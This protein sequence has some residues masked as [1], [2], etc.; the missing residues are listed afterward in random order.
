MVTGGQGGPLGGEGGGQPPCPP[1]LCYTYGVVTSENERYGEHEKH[2]Y[3]KRTREQQ[4]SKRQEKS[5]TLA[6]CLNMN[7]QHKSTLAL[8]TNL[9]QQLNQSHTARPPSVWPTFSGEPTYVLLYMPPERTRLFADR[10]RGC[11]LVD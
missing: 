4:P 1:P 5:C 9:M 8:F 7:L 2:N 10:L 11:R 3:S 6:E